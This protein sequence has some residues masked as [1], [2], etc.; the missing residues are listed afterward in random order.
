MLALNIEYRVSNFMWNQCWE[1]KQTK[2]RKEKKEKCRTCFQWN[3]RNGLN[4]E[5]KETFTWQSLSISE[6]Q[7]T[8]KSYDRLKR[9]FFFLFRLGIFPRFISKSKMFK[10]YYYLWVKRRVTCS[11][12]WA[13]RARSLADELMNQGSSFSLANK[14]VIFVKL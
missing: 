12:I 2:K 5:P 9:L 1:P 13:T 4:R 8:V 10:K 7:Q 14:S 11:A 6:Q 3:E